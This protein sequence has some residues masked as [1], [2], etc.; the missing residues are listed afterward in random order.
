[1]HRQPLLQLLSRYRSVFPDEGPVLERVRCFVSEHVDCFERSCLG[2]HVTASA[3]IVS[4]AGDAALLTHHKKLQRWL[5]LGGHVDGES[6]IEAACLREAQEESGMQTFTFVPWAG[7]ELV[8][9]DLDVHDIPARK[10]EPQH[11]HWDVRFLLQAASGQELVLSDESNE[12][13]WVPFAQLDQFTAEESVLRL[14]RK[15]MQVRQ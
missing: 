10:H 8:P 3:W 12:L 13:Q 15:A 5:Q 9:V 6:R 11:E 4:A 14:H 7:A 2:G 1:M